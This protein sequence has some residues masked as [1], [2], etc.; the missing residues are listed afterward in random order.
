MKTNQKKIQ[1]FTIVKYISIILL[2]CLV[3]FVSAKN[4]NSLKT[5]NL[6]S[7]MVC[8]SPQTSMKTIR[9]YSN[10]S[11]LKASELEFCYA[12][13]YL[14]KYYNFSFNLNNEN[15]DI[16]FIRL[17]QMLEACSLEDSSLEEEY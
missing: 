16:N 12:V 1:V 11:Y 14:H 6:N 2:V 7:S 4:G 13:K 10:V 3:S 5:I 8:I 9:N 15:T 17:G